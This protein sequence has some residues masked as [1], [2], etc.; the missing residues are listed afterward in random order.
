M[1]ETCEGADDEQSAGE[2]ADETYDDNGYDDGE[3]WDGEGWH[4][5]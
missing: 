2:E 4:E 1:A 3:G 5:G